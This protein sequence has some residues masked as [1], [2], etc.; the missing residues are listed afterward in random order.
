MFTEAKLIRRAKNLNVAHNPR[1][2]I[3]KCVLPGNVQGKTTVYTPQSTS[4]TL[5][6]KSWEDASNSGLAKT[7]INVMQGIN[8]LQELGRRNWSCYDMPDYDKIISQPIIKPKAA[9]GAFDAGQQTRAQSLSLPAKTP[10]P[11]PQRPS[12]WSPTAGTVRVFSP[13]HNRYV[14]RPV[15]AENESLRLTYYAICR[16]RNVHSICLGKAA[17]D[18]QPFERALGKIGVKKPYTNCEESFRTSWM[19]GRNVQPTENYESAKFDIV[20]HGKG[21]AGSITRIVGKNPRAC[22]KVKSIAEYSDIT[23]VNAVR[24]NNEY[25]AAVAKFPG[26]FAKTASL[27]S[28]QVDLGRT[29]G[30]FFKL[31]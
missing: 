24:T 25:R 1:N 17:A 11:Q 14:E 30:P 4:P 9:F 6:K 18:A 10:Q 15:A 28:S 22:N 26:C 2:L 3:E 19:D 21:Q 5:K 12:L 7:C 16:A 20:S 8:K 23:R 13:Q 27:C 29:Y 31:F